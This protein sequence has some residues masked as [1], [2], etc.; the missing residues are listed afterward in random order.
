MLMSVV[1]VP[2]YHMQFSRNLRNQVFPIA[3][4]VPINRYKKLCQ[5]IYCND[6]PERN[7][8]ENQAK[9]LYKIE[10]VL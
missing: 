4:I 5:Y 10:P 6:N 1:N 3:D 8:K 2:A 7:R 9:K